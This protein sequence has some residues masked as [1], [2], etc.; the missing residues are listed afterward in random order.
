MISSGR[1]RRPS[2]SDPR[3]DCATASQI[4]DVG[5][6]FVFYRDDGR[7]A[8][9]STSIHHLPFSLSLLPPPPPPP[10]P[11]PGPRHRSIKAAS[12]ASRPFSVALL[13]TKTIC[14]KRVGWEAFFRK[15]LSLSLSIT[16]VR[17][18]HPTR[19]RNTGRRR[20]LH[21]DSMVETWRLAE[22]VAA[23]AMNNSLQLPLSPWWHKSDTPK[24]L[25]FF[26]SLI[27]NHWSL[28]FIAPGTNFLDFS[29][30]LAF[31]FISLVFP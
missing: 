27:Y 2:I 4:L 9:V 22:R 6:R 1:R 12:F 24:F 15:S 29:S 17:W 23:A 13:D 14:I 30:P 31:T 11:P 5:E 7:F 8:P 19:L 3:T 16:S 28:H 18:G 10:P 20:R 26:S 25:V 21:S